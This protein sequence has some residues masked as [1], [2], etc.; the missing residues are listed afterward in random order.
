M[1]NKNYCLFCLVISGFLI[2]S[3]KV[4]WFLGYFIFDFFLLIDILYV[5]D[6]GFIFLELVVV[7]NVFKLF[8]VIINEDIYVRGLIILKLKYFFF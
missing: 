4:S 5:K 8:L 7:F 1:I 3:L 6:R 2:F